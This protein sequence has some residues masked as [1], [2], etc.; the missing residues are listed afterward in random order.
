M[1]HGARRI[2]GSADVISVGL[3]LDTIVDIMNCL[4]HS[5]L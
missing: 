1:F 5:H 4:G 3:T 2:I